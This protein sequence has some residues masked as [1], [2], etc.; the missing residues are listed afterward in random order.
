MITYEFAPD[1]VFTPKTSDLAK[2]IYNLRFGN[3]FGQSKEDKLKEEQLIMQLNELNSQMETN[4]KNEKLGLI[5]PIDFIDKM[6]DGFDRITKDINKD[7]DKGFKR[8]FGENFQGLSHQPSANIYKTENGVSL[9]MSVPGYDKKDID[10]SLE[11]NT[12]TVS[13]KKEENKQDFTMREFHCSSFSRSFNLSER[14]NRDTIKSSLNNGVLTVSIA[15]L[16]PETVNSEKK[17][18]PVD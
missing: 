8:V 10:I 6:V 18:I 9:E 13:G 14:L 5:H 3:V 17:K 15:K 12:L 16:Q 7:F 2:Q 1:I 11:K 4:N